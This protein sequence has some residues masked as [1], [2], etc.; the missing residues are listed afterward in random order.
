MVGTVLVLDD[1]TAV[2]ELTSLFLRRNGFTVLSSTSADSALYTFDKA[3]G[4]VD[5]LIADLE[6]PGSGSSGVEV[7]RQLK[8]R[9]PG[10]KTLFASGHPLQ[11]LRDTN[12]ALIDQL[13]GSTAVDFLSKPYSGPELLARVKQLLE[14]DS[15]TG[16]PPAS[17]RTAG[18][19]DTP[20]GQAT[21][22]DL[23]H[24]AI[25]VRNLE[26]TIQFWNHG[27]E[28]LY[29]WSKEEAIG[30]KT[31][32]LIHT[33]LPQPME[34]ILA[35]LRRTRNWEGELHQ[36]GRNGTTV[37]VSSRWAMRQTG[38]NQVEILEL[39]R[40]ITAQK[41]VEEGF[42]GVNREMQERL[43][44]LNRA[45]QMSRSLIEFA[46]DAMII[47]DAAGNIVLINSQ[48][49]RQFGYS[50]E[51]LLGQ[52]VE[53]LM[54]QR[55]RQDHSEFRAGYM[56]KPYFRPMGHHSH[57]VGLRKNREEFPVE[58]SLSAIETGTGILISSAVRDIS[59]RKRIEDQLSR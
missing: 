21:L 58:I 25:I 42:R 35:A 54:P 33:V 18:A 56:E 14:V 1:D 15:V 50:R 22:L 43:E 29:G 37:I 57:L 9:A 24:D 47:T 11:N 17:P 20:E 10:I 51:E 5:L 2:L 6:L 46:P 48:A 23:V 40:D 3:Q 53:I 52:S 44:E 38:N 26:G 32:D 8:A 45:E 49:E 16:T 59:G 41:R 34:V 39:N 7:A 31:E 27:A 13:G 19:Y 12:A 55:F 4:K 28:S 36:T 30:V